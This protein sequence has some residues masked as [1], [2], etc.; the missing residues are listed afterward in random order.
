MQTANGFLPS[1]NATIAAARPLVIEPWIS[2][3]PDVVVYEFGARL[4]ARSQA[5][6]TEQILK[7]RRLYNAVIGCI[8]TVHGELNV[9]V[10]KRR[11]WLSLK[12][13]HAAFA[14]S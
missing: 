11:K 8:R 7:A 13:F 1:S 6:A 9:W 14:A 4:D 5:A 12:D 10:G 2:P 3:A